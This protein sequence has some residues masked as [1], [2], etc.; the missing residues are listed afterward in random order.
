MNPVLKAFA[1][2]V[3]AALTPSLAS[4][5]QSPCS[6]SA[7]T[8]LLAE[9]FG[10]ECGVYKAPEPVRESLQEVR[11]YKD[12]MNPN[13]VRGAD[14]PEGDPLRIQRDAVKEAIERRR[15]N[16]E[17]NKALGLDAPD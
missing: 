13:S 3:T 4:A 9:I 5:G 17:A 1:L 12:L 15:A 11:R 8:A 10:V 16:E 6:R 7:P 2:S 14:L